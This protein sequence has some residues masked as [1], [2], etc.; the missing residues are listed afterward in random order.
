MAKKEESIELHSLQRPLRAVSLAIALVG[1]F[2]LLIFSIIINDAMDKTRDSLLSNFE[3]IKGSLLDIE[4]SLTTLGEGLNSANETI[5][6]LEESIVPL[7]YGLEATGDALESTGDAL[8]VLELLGGDAA[9]IKYEF[10]SA[11][12]SMKSSAQKLNESSTAFEEQRITLTQL[13]DDIDEMKGGISAQRQ[14]IGKTKS[15]FEEVFSLMKIANVLFFLVI[16]SMFVILILNS[17]AGL[18]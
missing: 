1:L 10:D 5:G 15:S 7:S 16:A 9:A 18:V 8:T 3:E 6:A 11:A 13:Q 4:N 2:V 12:M 14:S 17:I